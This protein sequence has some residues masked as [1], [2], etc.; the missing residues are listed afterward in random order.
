MDVEPADSLLD[1]DFMAGGQSQNVQRAFGT[2]GESPADWKRAASPQMA[3]G[4]PLDRAVFTNP[5]ALLAPFV[6]T[7]SKDNSWSIRATNGSGPNVTAR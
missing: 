3:S 2:V 5:L 6:T 1:G 7:L 4:F